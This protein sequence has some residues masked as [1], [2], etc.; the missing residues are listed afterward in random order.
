[1][2]NKT[3]CLKLII[4]IVSLAIF[5]LTAQISPQDSP[6]YENGA[7]DVIS[8]TL[9]DA[10]PNLLTF[11]PDASGQKFPVL[12]FQPGANAGS[13]EDIDVNTYNIYLE[14]LASYGYVVVIIDNTQGGPNNSIFRE[15]HDRVLAFAA[16]NS[17]WMS[18][19]A[20]VD[21]LAVGGHSNG[22]MNATE[23]IIQRPDDVKGIMYLGSYPNPGVIGLGAQNVSNYPGNV[24]LIVGDEDETS[25]PLVGTTNNVALNAYNNRFNS[26]E[27]KT[28]VELVGVGHGGFGDY[29]H[30]DHTVGTIGRDNV[31][32]SVRH[33]IVS[34]MELY[35]KSNEDVKPDLKHESRQPNATGNFLTNCPFSLSKP[36]I[37]VIGDLTFCEGDS[38]LLYVNTDLDVLWSTNETSDTIVVKESGSYTV[39]LVL[40]DDESESSDAV[41]VE[42]TPSADASWD[43]PATVCESEGTIDLNTLVTGDA[44][45]VWSGTGV[46]DGTFDPSGLAGQEISITYTLDIDCPDEVTHTISV[47][48]DPS[49]DWEVPTT[50]CVGEVLDLTTLVT[51]DAGGSWSGEGVEGNTWTTAGLSG[52][53]ELTYTV[54]PA[55]CQA[56]ETK[57]VMLSNLPDAPTILVEGLAT[58]CEGETVQ[59]FVDSDLEVVWSTDEEGVSIE[60][61]ASG[62][63]TAQVISEDGCFSA[64]SESFEVIVN[65][66][67]DVSWTSPETVCLTSGSVDLDDLVTGETGG[68]WSGE[69]VEGGVFNPTGL[70]DQTVSITYTVELEGCENS[71]THEI[72]VTGE[73]SAMWEA[74]ATLCEGELVD[75]NTYLAGD[76]GGTWS[77]EGVVGD[78]F[79][80]AGL[81]G[82]IEITYM[83]ESGDCSDEMTNTITVV[84]L[85][86][87]PSISVDGEL[88]LCEGES[89]TLSVNSSLNVL[90]STGEQTTEIEI[91]ESGV[92]SVQLINAEGCV[93]E[94]SEEVTVVVNPLPDASWES[95]SVICESDDALVLDDFVTGDVGGSWSGQGVDAGVFNPDG[96][97]GEIEI[98]YTVEENGCSSDEML[99]VMV[100]ENVSAAWESFETICE[101]ESL[102][103][104]DLLTGTTG[105]TWSGNGV[106]GSLFDAT[107]LNGSVT[108]S[109]EVGSG[110]CSDE[111]SQT[112]TVIVIDEPEV[113][114][115]NGV[116]TSSVSGDNYQWYLN[117]NPIAGAT[118][119]SYAPTVSGD[120]SVTVIE[121]GCSATSGDFMYEVLSIEK[122]VKSSISIYPNPASTLVTVE[123]D[124]TLVS[125]FTVV[126]LQGTLI[127]TNKSSN[128]VYLDVT[129]YEKGVYLINFIST[130]RVYLY[131]TKLIVN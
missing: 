55:N 24:I 9:S 4:T 21:N 51:G 39:K 68:T 98:T 83:V 81:V 121:E 77:G 105:G 34:F 124:E 75:L 20:D 101:G 27:C 108:I 25:V 85:P 41:S 104:N 35:L 82:G 67:P 43:A 110:N 7:Y 120:Y 84:P 130:E 93:S 46:I 3:T 14:H 29:T 92:Y 66:L 61:E 18:E 71:E 45:G 13:A 59:L 72:S 58:V 2:T 26:V 10:T 114:E 116:L 11:R 33:Y 40:G 17:H 122:L 103:L 86:T 102:D 42:V 95:P 119:Q 113:E 36:T 107:G 125:G 128:V 31:T 115:D 76:T 89:T 47:I 80:T 129:N 54:G 100:V 94:A 50:V 78:E 52:V 131:T 57:E 70:A 6:Y 8:E 30:P 127:S 60:V 37:E 12:I 5:N 48:G 111:M 106:I 63:Y 118:D 19:L 32:A 88:T 56:L 112:I 23:L 16:D 62:N 90:W 91:S 1:M 109:Y 123:M 87:T 38:V 15:T 117:G 44:G 96:L 28:F 99:V 126:S 53:V 22:G 73:L 79:N 49:A 97:S 65:P 64:V 74:P 69:G